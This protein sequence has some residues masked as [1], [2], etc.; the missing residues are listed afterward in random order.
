LAF[1]ALLI[2]KVPSS[3]APSKPRWNPVPAP[4]TIA[5]RR[6]ADWQSAVSPTGSR[7]GVARAE[8]FMESPMFLR[9][10]PHPMKPF[11]LGFRI[12]FGF[13]HSGFGFKPGSWKVPCS[14]RTCSRP[15]NLLVVAQTGSLLM[16]GRASARRLATSGRLWYRHPTP[17]CAPP[18]ASR[19]H[20]RQTVCATT[21]RPQSLKEARSPPIRP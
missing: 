21:A 1:S 5:A 4:N 17:C 20:S 19:R 14:I 2:F 9:T 6:G 11:R 7:Q 3:R 12:S 8:R 10:C 16:A 18:T 13:R 15:M